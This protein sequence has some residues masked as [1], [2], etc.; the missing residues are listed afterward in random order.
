M[1]WMIEQVNEITMKF[2]GCLIKRHEQ[3]HSATFLF[4]NPGNGCGVAACECMVV[5]SGS[6][7]DGRILYLPVQNLPIIVVIK[8]M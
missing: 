2:Y 7:T 5:R 8:W 4:E 1:I 3:G 6:N